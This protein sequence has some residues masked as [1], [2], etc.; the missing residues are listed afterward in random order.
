MASPTPTA[1]TREIITTTGMVNSVSPS[2]GA[3]SQSLVTDA[4]LEGVRVPDKDFVMVRDAETDAVAVSVE[5]VLGD[6]DSDAVMLWVRET[7]TVTVVV[8]EGVR[9]LLRVDDSV[10]VVVSD[11]ERDCVPLL[12]SVLEALLDTDGL[13]V[14]VT[15]VD[16]VYV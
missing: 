14:V 10:L 4:V 7:D 6:R 12:D 15:D 11:A 13:V 1:V 8:P 16:G 2:T 5:L 9:V 3:P